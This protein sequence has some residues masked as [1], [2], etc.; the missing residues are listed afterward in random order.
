MRTQTNFVE[1]MDESDTDYLEVWLGSVKFDI[2][3]K[4]EELAM[5]ISYDYM[6]TRSAILKAKSELHKLYGERNDIQAQLDKAMD[7][8]Y[9]TLK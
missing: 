4:Q 3:M 9:F 8:K 2:D 1:F 5:L 7:V 6:A